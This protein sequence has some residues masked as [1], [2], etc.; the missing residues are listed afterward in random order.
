M[1]STPNVSDVEYNF[2]SDSDD[3]SYQPGQD[4]DDIDLSHLEDR[5]H[6]VPQRI[7]VDREV[8]GDSSDENVFSHDEDDQQDDEDDDQD[9]DTDDDDDA[10]TPND[11]DDSDDEG[12]GGLDSSWRPVFSDSD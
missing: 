9:D 3:D 10:E 8:F 5:N 11:S 2:S 1:L 6:D 4:I 12:Q 7:G